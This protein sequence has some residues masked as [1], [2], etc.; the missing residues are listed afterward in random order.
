MQ[1]R[2]S[3]PLYTIYQIAPRI[4]NLDQPL[5]HIEFPGNNISSNL[6]LC[7]HLTRFIRYS[8][9][10]V[11]RCVPFPLDGAYMAD[12]GGD[13]SL[14]LDAVTVT[15]PIDAPD[16]V[17]A[18][19]RFTTPEQIILPLLLSPSS[20]IPPVWNGARA[21][22]S[23]CCFVVLLTAVQVLVGERE[24]VEGPACPSSERRAFLCLSRS[25]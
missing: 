19:A 6:V 4:R 18:Y 8:T 5:N 16:S 9:M 12:V 10:G 25:D 11:I 15:R 24:E 13:C 17:S 22:A 3:H 14:T 20:L 7:D 21:A 2:W 1:S 23:V